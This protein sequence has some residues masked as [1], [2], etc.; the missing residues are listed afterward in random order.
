MKLIKIGILTLI[1]III[2][3]ISVSYFTTESNIIETNQN[4]EKT[5]LIEWDSG[6]LFKVLVDPKDIRVIDG[7]SI[8]LKA[9]FGL[10]SELAETYNEIG[11]F[12]QEDKP[13]VIIPTFTSS[14][15]APFGFYDYYNERCGEQCL[16]VKIVSED[17]LDYKSSANGVKILNLLGY[18]SISDLELHK[19]PNILNDYKKIIVLHNEYVSK[20]M[21]DALTLHKNVVFLYP[22]ALYAEIEIDIAN[23]QITLIRGHGYPESTIVNGFNWE[24]E[25]T[26]P[27]E[28]DNECNNFEFYKIPNGFMLNCYPEQAIWQNSSLL[29]ALKEL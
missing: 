5:E 16:T 28:Y 22:N 9:T 7:E 18:D 21:F 2:G 27:Y 1:I 26:H 25:N 11:V 17:K 19:N 14:A 13:L 29:K 10:K 15:Y 6:N 4:E 8:P 12:D 23:N 3:T 24:N 20:I